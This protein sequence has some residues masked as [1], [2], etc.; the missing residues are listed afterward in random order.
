[1]FNALLEG[2]FESV[3]KKEN[4]E[5]Q[6]KY[7]TSLQEPAK[8]LHESYNTQ[9]G[10][11]PKYED[12]KTRH[13]YLLRYFPFYSQLLPEILQKN[14]DSLPKKKHL[15][16]TFFGCGPAP[17]LVGLLQFLRS[18]TKTRQVDANL[19]DI[20]SDHWR[21]ARNIAINYIAA[22]NWAQRF[23]NFVFTGKWERKLLKNVRLVEA[24][25]ADKMM[26]SS[27][28]ISGLIRKSDLVVFQNFLNE[29]INDDDKR[30]ATIEN[31]KQT[32]EK[33][34]T[35]SIGIIIDCSGYHKIDKII[36]E[37]LE[38][39]QKPELVSI[40]NVGWPECDCREK[41]PHE[42]EKITDGK[43]FYL[44][45]DLETDRKKNPEWDG[46]FLR[47]RIAYVY[48]AFRKIKRR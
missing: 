22:R 4:R 47:R 45:T 26:F 38:W 9:D 33:L 10:C 2:I 21:H 44:T 39:G 40:V 29:I 3:G 41:W 32:L 1:M 28:D 11:T 7:L 36:K 25:I 46:L 34:P 16:A 31:M 23:S 8:A 19:V 43:P 30:L 17:E 6:I 27:S 24:D 35:N 42:I 13:A 20:A 12:E 15:T 48:L 37:L 14:N 18:N 5:E